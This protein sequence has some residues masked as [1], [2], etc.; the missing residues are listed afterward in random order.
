M[1]TTPIDRNTETA[2]AGRC[3]RPR[4]AVETP[5]A[6]H[7]RRGI[8]VELTLRRRESCVTRRAMLTAMRDAELQAWLD[9]G[10]DYLD[11]RRP[12]MH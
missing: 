6:S 5:D 7:Q 10:G 8:R 9:S 1:Q 3:Y 12:L 11:S 4:L 2:G